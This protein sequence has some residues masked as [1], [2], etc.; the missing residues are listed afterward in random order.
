MSERGQSIEQPIIR[1]RKEFSVSTKA[2][3]IKKLSKECY[4]RR[5]TL[6]VKRTNGD[7]QT[8]SEVEPEYR[9]DKLTG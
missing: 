4:E 8:I 2:A 9:Y 3:Y 5:R 7:W 6:W 1:S